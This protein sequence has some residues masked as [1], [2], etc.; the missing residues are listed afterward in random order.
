MRLELGFRPVQLF[1][2]GLDDRFDARARGVMSHTQPL[3]LRDQHGHELPSADHQG[4]QLLSLFSPP[5]S[6]DLFSNNCS[7][8]RE[9]ASPCAIC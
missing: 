9:T 5:C 3:A 1:L 8:S 2:Q 6:Y 7:C 4:L